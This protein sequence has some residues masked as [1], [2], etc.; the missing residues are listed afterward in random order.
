MC[1]HCPSQR[2]TA[3]E[4]LD[5]CSGFMES[6]GSIESGRAAAEYRYFIPLKPAEIAVLGTVRK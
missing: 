1:G 3:G 5:F 4:N 2:E 6:G